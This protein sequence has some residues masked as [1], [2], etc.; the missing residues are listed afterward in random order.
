M[1][2]DKATA[3]GDVSIKHFGADGELKGVRQI[4][5][6]VVSA[7]TA[8]IASR[9]RDATAAVISHMAMG[10]G[11]TAAAADQ[12]A[13]VSELG[14]VALDS[15]DGAANKAVYIATFGP[16]VATGALTEAAMFNAAS[17]GTMPA[18]TVFPVVTKQDLDSIVLTWTI[19]INN[20]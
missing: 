17:A 16:Y 2:K 8:F 6:L 19:T 1:I 9:M 7:G 10:S 4:H 12:T 13:L 14:R 11:T 20:G 18:R 5:N 3:I 15:V